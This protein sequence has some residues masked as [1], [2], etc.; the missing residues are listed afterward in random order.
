MKIVVFNTSAKP[1]DRYIYIIDRFGEIQT[2][3]CSV[4]SRETQVK[5]H[6]ISQLTAAGSDH[7]AFNFAGHCLKDLARI[8][9]PGTTYKLE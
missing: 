6:E 9:P 8:F 5:L 4:Q 3:R 2:H 1:N 7:F